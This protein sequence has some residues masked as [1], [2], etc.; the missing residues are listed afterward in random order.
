MSITTN[1]QMYLPGETVIVL[2]SAF[3]GTSPFDTTIDI[4]IVKDG[5]FGDLSYFY[6]S[7]VLSKNGTFTIPGYSAPYDLGRYHISASIP[8]L[9]PFTTTI[10]EVVNPLFTIQYLM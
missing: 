7:R 6:T 9:A 5:N 3:N 2:G 4:K 8:D 10:Y 1:K